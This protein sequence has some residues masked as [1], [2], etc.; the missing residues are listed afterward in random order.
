LIFSANITKNFGIYNIF[1]KA[2]FDSHLSPKGRGAFSLFEGI[3]R[4][5]IS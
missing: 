2:A 4:I 3:K 5:W 1:E